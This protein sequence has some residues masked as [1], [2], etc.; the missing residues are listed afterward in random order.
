MQTWDYVNSKVV[1]TSKA[2]GYGIT[3]DQLP[4]GMRRFFKEDYSAHPTDHAIATI[5]EEDPQKLPAHAQGETMTSVDLDETPRQAPPASSSIDSPKP[6]AS[7][8]AHLNAISRV[9]SAAL[10]T[11]DE[12]IR[13]FEQLE[14]RMVGA[15][16]LIVYEGDPDR[17]IEAWRLADAGKARADGLEDD[18]HTGLDSDPDDD[19]EAGGEVME[20]EVDADMPAQDLQQLIVRLK[21]GKLPASEEERVKLGLPPASA[22][23][24]QDRY[25]PL[26]SDPE[27]R[28]N[29]SD[30]SDD[31]EH[32]ASDDEEER[33]PRPFSLRLIDFAHTRLAHGE[34]PDEGVLLGMRTLRKLLQ[35]RKEEI[36]AAILTS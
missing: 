16:I 30:E 19:S 9:L 34:G 36:D 14:I 10:V 23:W 31:D 8:S 28:R 27:A 18:V 2:F 5:P 7:R 3:A 21:Q 4:D 17:L 33:R 29:A 25:N 11:L 6:V 32:I 15:S 12:L 20:V 22:I 24:S 35:G 13:L 1:S 26:A